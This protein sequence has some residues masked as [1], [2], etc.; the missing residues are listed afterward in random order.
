LVYCD[1]GTPA[2][3]NCAPVC[4]PTTEIC[5]NGID[6]D[7]DG[8][9]LECPLPSEPV[10]TIESPEDGRT[11]NTHLII[12]NATADQNI[13]VW[14][15][16]LNGGSVNPLFNGAGYVFPE[17]CHELTVY[18]ENSNGVGTDTVNFCVN[19]SFPDN[20]DAPVVTIESPEDGR[21]Y[22]F[23]EIEVNATADQNIDNWTFNVDGGIFMN[24]SP[25]DYYNFTEGCHDMIVIGENLN[26]TGMDNVHFCIDLG[27]NDPEDPEEECN[28]C[29]KKKNCYDDNEDDDF[30]PYAVDDIVLDL[31]LGRDR[32]SIVLGGAEDSDD[33]FR[34]G[35]YPVLIGLLLLGIIVVVI[36]LLLLAGGD[37]D[38]D[39]VVNYYD[40]ETGATTKDNFYSGGESLY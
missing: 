22:N 28:D 1:D 18:G 15:F 31:V 13:D 25:G 33:G 14:R 16:E 38:K 6:E 36:L 37:D 3:S 27:G 26:G 4:T 35:L 2:V 7:C 30:N 23:T 34:F 20:P 19:L 17:G 9:D 5:G 21:T 29:N 11:Y 39:R 24:F 8:S 32:E 12:V 40:V 10:V